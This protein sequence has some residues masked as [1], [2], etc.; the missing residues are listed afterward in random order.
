MKRDRMRSSQLFP[1]LMSS[2]SYI[3]RAAS[4]T[5]S[6]WPTWRRSF[7]DN[8]LSTSEQSLRETLHGC[9]FVW[10][11]SRLTLH[12]DDTSTVRVV[13]GHLDSVLAERTRKLVSI[14]QHQHNN[15]L[16]LTSTASLPELVKKKVS[17]SGLG[18]TGIN[19]SM[20]WSWEREWA[21]LT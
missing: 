9:E 11:V 10:G 17:S 4:D 6:S 3:W 13:L 5:H 14:P 19:F 15:R 16:S 8:C 20:S 12:D 1:A 7:R 18:M 2:L 21:M